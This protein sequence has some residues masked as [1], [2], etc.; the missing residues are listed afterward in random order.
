MRNQKKQNIIQLLLVLGIIVLANIVSSFVFTRVDLTSDKRFTLSPSSKDLVG[1]L[2]DIVFVKVYL[3]GDFPAGFTKLHNATRELLDE[4]RTYSN[5]N[6]EYEFIDPSANADPKER[7]NLYRQLAEK[8]LQPTNLEEKNKEASSQKIIFPGAIV[9]F[10]NQEMPVQLLKDQLGTAPAEMLNNSIQNLEYEITSAIRKVTNPY[11][12][13]IGF[14][15]GHG[16]LSTSA[17]AD[18]TNTLNSSYDVKRVRI[19][20]ILGSL[21]EFR[22]IIIAKPDSAFNEITKA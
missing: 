1:K 18:I 16:E 19:D 6:L 12:P 10:S 8:G 4:L 3:E 21:A 2:K 20:G 9:S 11:K 14:V 5:G 17:V 13:S 7:N 15:E 22:A